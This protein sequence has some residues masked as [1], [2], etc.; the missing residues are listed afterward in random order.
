MN[1][2][3]CRIWGTENPHT[4]VVSCVFWVGGVIE[5]YF[6]EYADGIAVTVD[7]LHYHDMIANFFQLELN[8]IS[9]N[10]MW[11]QQD[12][13]TYHIALETCESLHLWG[14]I[15]SKVYTDLM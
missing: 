1:G 14:V 2:Q 3:N 5:S 12:G 9:L 8:E 6:S 13:A 11:F 10:N 4:V 15:K 7:G